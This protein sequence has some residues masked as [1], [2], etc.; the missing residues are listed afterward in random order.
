MDYKPPA[1]PVALARPVFACLSLN[2]G[3]RL[4][5]INFPPEAVQW[6]EGAIKE[7]RWPYGVQSTQVY[8]GRSF[9]FK[10]NGYPWH[11]Q[12]SEAVGSRRLMLCILRTLKSHGF[13]I[14]TST[15]MSR[16]ESD[17]DTLIFRRVQPE[18][19]P[20]TMFSISLNM[21]DKLRLIDAPPLMDTVVSECITQFWSQGLQR[22]QRL[23]A[24]CTEFKLHGY[25]WSG[26]S[27]DAVHSRYFVMNL[28]SLLEANG[29]RMYASIDMSSGEADKDSWFFEAIV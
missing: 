1:V 26:Q 9:E 10:L 25:P 29:W 6:I 28:L 11:G 16:S 23:G 3:D 18:E 5:L 17:K 2:R 14:V 4:R 13:H 20:T 12:G 22:T 19:T 8:A 7:S 24:G 27:T 15:D 21:G